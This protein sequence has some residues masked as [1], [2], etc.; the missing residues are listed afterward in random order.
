MERS[1][2]GSKR[3]RFSLKISVQ[4]NTHRKKEE[5]KRNLFFGRSS[6][7]YLFWG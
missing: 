7:Q 5:K 3:R 6:L 4:E 2:T 1:L